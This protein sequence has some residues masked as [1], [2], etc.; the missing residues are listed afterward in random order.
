MNDPASLQNLNDIVLPASVPW[1]PPAPGWYVLSAVVLGVLLILALRGW[2]RWR[3]N[4]Y[5][6][7]ALAS[8]AAMRAERLELQ[9]LP[10]LL[11]R[12][13]L[14]AWPRRQV[15]GLHGR[16]WHEFLDESG[17]GGRFD[18]GAGSILDRLSYAGAG[19]EPPDAADRLRV[20][21]AAETWLRRHRVPSEA[22]GT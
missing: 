12:A 5:R 13:A 20:L 4:A 15:A 3:R 2:R 22:G 19:T 17:G 9:Y 1:W 8:V 21:E 14:S 7:Q 10:G 11:K 16:A 18:E 6:R